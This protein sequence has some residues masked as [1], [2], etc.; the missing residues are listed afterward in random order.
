MNMKQVRPHCEKNLFFCWTITTLALRIRQMKKK[1]CQVRAK[2]IDQDEVKSSI[3]LV[4]SNAGNGNSFFS[5]SILASDIFR[6]LITFSVA[7]IP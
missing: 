3:V 2:H 6:N 4:S 7:A 1:C 5:S